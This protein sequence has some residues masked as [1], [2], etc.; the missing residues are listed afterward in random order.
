MDA[1]SVAQSVTIRSA[2]GAAGADIIRPQK[3]ETGIMSL[4]KIA[5][6]D[7]HS[8]AR[9]AG[10]RPGETLT[11][12]NGHPIADVLDYKFYAYDPRL[13][14][15]LTE[16]DGRSRTLRLQKEEGEDLGLNFET[17]LMDRARS[18]ANRCIFCFVD[19]MPPGMRETLYFKDDDARLSFLLGNYITLTNLSAREID[20]ICQLRIS[21]VNI[22]V[23]ATDP[24][25][26]E[27][28][29]KHRR[30]GECLEIMGRFAAAGIEMNC[31]VVACPGVNDGPALERTLADLGAL[32][33][34][35]ASVAVVPVGVTKFREGLCPIEP[36]TKAQAAALVDQV[37]AFAARFLEQHGTS[38][39]WC[40]D[41]FYLI[42]GRALPEKSYYEDMD[43]L[44]NG[45]GMLRLL[46][47]QAELAL[48]DEQTEQVPPFAVAT[49]VSAAPFVGKVVDMVRE[50][51]G[52]IDGRVYPV[53]NHFFG[54]TITVSG[55]ITGADLLEQLKGRALGARLLIPDNMLRAG[56]RV[57]LDDVTVEELEQALG[58]PVVPVPAD[59]GFDLVDAILGREVGQPCPV[60]PPEAEYYR[61]NP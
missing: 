9:R 55:L 7:P 26:R 11:H 12:I 25:L 24:A 21:P 13:E 43:Q 33:P 35:V 19:Q 42:A 53:V 3:K 58:V 56:E 54:E 31:Q 59:S 51:C 28:M 50:K 1:P 20:R 41:E 37:E 47:R 44:E 40:S 23:H 15:T 8:P 30:A 52:N 46:L 18:C 2:E 14:L 57:F 5:S 32:W 38:L 6:V 27:A 4:T 45:V 16:P 34:A 36:Y 39:A 61:Y 48:E 17:Y 60:L 49:G 10:V 22:S 29:L